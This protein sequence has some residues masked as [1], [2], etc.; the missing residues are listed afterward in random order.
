MLRRDAAFVCTLPQLD[1]YCRHRGS[2]HYWPVEIPIPAAQHG[3]RNDVI[4][5]LPG[6]HPAMSL[7]DAAAEQSPWRFL[8]YSGTNR[9]VPK[10]GLQL[11]DVPLDLFHLLPKARI[12]IHHGG[13]GT[14][15]WCLIHRVPQVIFPM[16]MEKLLIARGLRRARAGVIC[17]A[18]LPPSD[19]ANLLTQF[20]DSSAPAADTA[21][22]RTRSDAETLCALLQASAQHNRHA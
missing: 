18:S 15:N 17:D 11:S 6:D 20:A 4:V 5:Y 19:F 21:T 12:A 22:M 14:A 10:R 9:S 2:E 3:P 16:D 13:L 7:V 8:A 1:P